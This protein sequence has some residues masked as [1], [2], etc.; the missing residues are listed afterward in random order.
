MYY[1]RIL[2]VIFQIEKGLLILGCCSNN[3]LY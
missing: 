1:N 3:C 2:S